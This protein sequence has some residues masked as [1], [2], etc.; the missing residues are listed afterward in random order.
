MSQ[1]TTQS[2]TVTYCDA[3][4]A[5][6]L[7]A[8]PVFVL[9]NGRSGSTLMRFLLDAHPDL[10]CPPETNLPAL[11]A[12]LATVWS[13]IE[14]A[15]LSMNRG[16]EPPAIPDA[17]ITG[18]RDTMDRMVGSYLIRKGRKRYCDKSLGTARFAELLVRVY[19]ATKFI[20]LYRHP[21]D[22]IASGLEACPWG[23]NGYGF[24]PYIAT[25]PG[26]AVHALARFWAEHTAQTL[27]T[28][29]RFP[30]HCIRVRYEDLVTDPE[31]VAA[32]IFTFLGVEPV[33]GISLTCFSGERERFGA[34][35]HKIW[36]TSKISSD[37]IGRGWSIPSGLIDP[38]LLTSINEQAQILGYLPVDSHWG[39]SAPPADLRLPSGDLGAGDLGAGD[40]GAG[41]PGAGDP[42]AGADAS[43][44]QAAV[45]AMAETGLWHGSSRSHSLG[46][47]LQAGLADTD[48]E[49]LAQLRPR[50]GA[51]MVVVSIPT[52]PHQA[53]E[54][55]L[56]DFTNRTVSSATAAAQEDSDWDVI[57]S[58]DAWDQVIAGNL[59]LSAALRS[60]QLRCCDGD[61]SAG[62]LGADTRIAMLAQLLGIAKWRGPLLDD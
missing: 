12:Q 20:C 42:G 33:P 56:I 13:L 59:N 44:Q 14:G 52:D 7:F 54:H 23:L 4:S 40:P 11:C 6:Q 19:P 8:D 35:D 25:T 43:S 41:D 10:A 26:N 49:T 57:G 30:E 9:C 47:R 24:D 61:D 17:A 48:P 2:T 32:K 28:E 46:G 39:T 36:C 50:V 5:A 55:W 60:C 22:V 27:A 45:P 34:G 37:S 1:S 53:A 58:A 62:P 21:M 3:T 31:E 18:I 29:E 38:R 16:D 51:T 15:P